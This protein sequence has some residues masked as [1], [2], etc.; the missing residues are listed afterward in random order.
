M[1][2]LWLNPVSAL[3]ESW[4]QS[5]MANAAIESGETLFDSDVLAWSIKE[6]GR[7]LLVQSS[8]MWL[9]IRDTNGKVFYRVSH[10][11]LDRNRWDLCTVMGEPIPFQRDFDTA[12]TA[13]QILNFIDDTDWSWDLNE[14]SG[15]VVFDIATGTMSEIKGFKYLDGRVSKSAWKKR[16]G[17]TF[18]HDI[19]GEF[20][21]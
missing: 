7:P 6:D 4:N 2:F 20:L 13:A 5:E 17:R 10:I 18:T 12:P 11:F 16:T 9:K 3:P 15:G 14:G 19:P 8:I 1:V 21:R